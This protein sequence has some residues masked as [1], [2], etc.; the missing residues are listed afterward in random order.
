MT[1][2]LI[3]LTKIVI[4][5]AVTFQHAFVRTSHALLPPQFCPSLRPSAV[6]YSG[7]ARQTIY[8]TEWCFYRFL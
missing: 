2:T 4:A 6:C 8:T 7:D 5:A 1:M 3:T